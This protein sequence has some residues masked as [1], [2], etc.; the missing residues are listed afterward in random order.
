M[1]RKYDDEQLAD[2]V[3]DSGGQD[4]PGADRRRL[5][6]GNFVIGNTYVRPRVSYRTRCSPVSFHRNQNL[7]F[8]MQVY[9]LGIDEKSK[10]NSATVQYTITNTESNKIVLDTSED[11]KALG[12]IRIN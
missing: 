5:A 9:N 8:W 3:P 6:P 7:N 1:F 2:F 10:T 12:G 11:S 4:A